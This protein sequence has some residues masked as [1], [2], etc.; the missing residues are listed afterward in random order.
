LKLEAI[1]GWVWDELDEKWN[2]GYTHLKLFFEIN[3][4]S[5]P[6]AKHLT[7]DGFRLGQWVQ[8]QRSTKDNLSE[9]RIKKLNDLNF[10]WDLN[11]NTWMENFKALIAYKKEFGHCKVPVLYK[12]KNDFALGSW[13]SKQ[14]TSKYVSPERKKQLDALGFVWEIKKK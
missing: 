6:E 1:K 10:V 8:V 11:E 9:D 7:K 4:H 2:N 3:K 5:S 14:R 13:V 12:T